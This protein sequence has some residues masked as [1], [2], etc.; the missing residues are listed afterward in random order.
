MY[1]AKWEEKLS[2]WDMKVKEDLTTNYNLKVL[3]KPAHRSFNRGWKLHMFDGLMP[4]IYNS[5]DSTNRGLL[6]DK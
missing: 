3:P 5:S 6:L 4:Q 2:P 1:L